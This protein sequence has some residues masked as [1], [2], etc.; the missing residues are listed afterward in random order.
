[1]TRFWINK[2]VHLRQVAMC[3]DYGISFEKDCCEVVAKSADQVKK[4]GREV[5]SERL[6]LACECCSNRMGVY[7]L[8]RFPGCSKEPMYTV[9]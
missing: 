4:G 9:S 5:L 7:L 2:E 6:E 1:M 8:W 3:Q